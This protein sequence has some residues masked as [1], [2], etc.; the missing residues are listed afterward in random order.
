MYIF[1]S[2][3]ITLF[4]KITNAATLFKRK[5]KVHLFLPCYF[6]LHC[7]WQPSATYCFFI[8]VCIWEVRFKTSVKNDRTS[9]KMDQFWLTWVIFTELSGLAFFHHDLKCTRRST[10]VLEANN[11]GEKD[12]NVIE[13]VVEVLSYVYIELRLCGSSMLKASYCICKMK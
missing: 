11:L 7:F 13:N 10:Q 6:F 3:W 5:N 4:E 2:V 1:Y 12:V 9:K 8:M